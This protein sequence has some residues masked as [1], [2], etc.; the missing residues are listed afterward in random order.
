MSASRTRAQQPWPRRLSLTDS[1]RRHLSLAR[2]DPSRVPRLSGAAGRRR[3]SRLGFGASSHL[4]NSSP[5]IFKLKKNKAVRIV[6]LYPPT[7]L[8]LSVLVACIASA[9][10]FAPAAL[11]YGSS[12][13][14]G[15][16]VSELLFS[17]LSVSKPALI[18]PV[19]S[20]G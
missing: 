3:D 4:T 11:P 14:A 13:R 8:R 18:Y 19:C 20:G 9:S 10:A 16:F 7:M 6:S 1:G 12:S 17:D 5:V 2:Y 15:K